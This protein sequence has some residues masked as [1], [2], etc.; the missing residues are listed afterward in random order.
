MRVCC[1]PEDARHAAVIWEVYAPEA[2]G[3]DKL[4]YRRSIAA[5]DDGGRWVF[6]ETG[7]RYPFERPESYVAPRKRDRFTRDMLREYLR[8]FDVELFEDGFMRIDAASPAVR[9][10]QVT[11]VQPAPEFTLEEVLA[12]VPWQR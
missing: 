8:H 6:E 12:G 9:L 11:S 7:E 5:A 2:Q 1:T 3:G 10:Q 4:G